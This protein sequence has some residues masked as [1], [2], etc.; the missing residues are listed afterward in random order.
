MEGL[1]PGKR[2]EEF[3]GYSGSL[4]SLSSSSFPYTVEKK[5]RTIYFSALR[6]GEEENFFGPCIYQ[7]PVDQL[8]EVRHPDPAPPGEALLEV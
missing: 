3:K 6:N 5:D 7:S 1:R 8:L 2:I 4:G